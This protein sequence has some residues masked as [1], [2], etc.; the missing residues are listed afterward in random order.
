MIGEVLGQVSAPA[1][2]ILAGM[3][4]CPAMPPPAVETQFINNSPQYYHHESAQQLSGYRID[5]VISHKPNEVFTVG[6]LTESRLNSTFEIHYQSQTRPGTGETC[7]WVDKVRLAYVYAPLVHVARENA[8]GSCRYEVIIRHELR[9]VGI[10]IITINEFLPRIE[11]AIKGILHGM[12]PR[13]PMPAAGIEEAR[14]AYMEAVRE[15]LERESMDMNRVRDLRQKGIDTRE[16][17][18]RLSD[19]CPQESDRR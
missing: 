14:V 7:V 1:A 8:P 16:E 2:Y 19:L 13:G 4:S 11:G 10:D 9:H 5:T 17:Y 18:S 3:M 6:G 12:G 15:R